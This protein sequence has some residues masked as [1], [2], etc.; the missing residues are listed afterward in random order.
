M[1]LLDLQHAQGCLSVVPFSGHLGTTPRLNGVLP[2]RVRSAR[3]ARR[4]LASTSLY[5]CKAKPR[6][7]HRPF[8]THEKSLHS[9]ELDHKTMNTRTLFPSG[10]FHSHQSQSADVF[11]FF[12]LWLSQIV[13]QRL[14]HFVLVNMA[15]K[16]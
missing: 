11:F 7:L 2:E 14:A 15:R 3:A 1:L 10:H 5:E 12:W 16:A 6:A 13:T 9:K 4:S 8:D